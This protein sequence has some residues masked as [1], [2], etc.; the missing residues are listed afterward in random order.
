MLLKSSLLLAS[1]LCLQA[2]YAEYYV[3]SPDGSGDLPTIQG[4]I[5]AACDGDVVILSDGIF[6]GDG[7]RDLTYSGKAITIR[8][9]SDNPENC[10]LDCGGSAGDPHRG[11][12][13]VS[14]ETRESVLRGVT[15]R[16]GWAQGVDIA[17]YSGG[18]ILCDDA[19]STI[20]NCIFRGNSAYAGGAVMVYR[21]AD[22]A[23]LDCLFEGNHA[24]VYE[25]AGGLCV[26][27]SANG[28]IENCVFRANDPVGM[29]SGSGSDPVIR[30][31]EFIGHNQCGLI[32]SGSSFYGRILV[33]NCRFF[34]NLGPAMLSVGPAVTVSGC[35]FWNNRAS[36][37][38]GLWLERDA[39]I[40]VIDSLFFDNWADETGAAVWCRYAGIAYF[41]NCT[42]IG[43]GL[44]NGGSVIDCG[45]ATVTMTNCIIAF[46]SGCQAVGGPAQLLCSDIYGNSGGDWMGDIAGQYGVNGNISEDPL[47]CDP[48]NFDFSLHADSP[49]APFSPPNPECDLIGSEPVGCGST[50]TQ[51]TTWGAM[52]ALFR[53]DGK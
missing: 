30:N 49:C 17:D 21:G 38:A 37:G 31:C 51:E 20:E 5:D 45:P 14:N 48:D 7:N 6:V 26:C 34:D 27:V 22:P 13:F 12:R 18:A 41:E 50:P 3:V 15:I 1:V 24:Y 32:C 46:S 29:T 8:S 4:A 9:E 42:F 52:K 39:D 53:G 19:S 43:N 25:G 10:I 40:R 2:A 35:S 23:I 16:N 36:R 47:F 11:V 28:T 44:P 33:D